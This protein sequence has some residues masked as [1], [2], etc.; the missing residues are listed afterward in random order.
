MIILVQVAANS[1]GGWEQSYLLRTD[2]ATAVKGY[3]R[4]T[5]S[6]QKLN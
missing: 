6:F 3:V 1:G 4:T 5:H 2:T